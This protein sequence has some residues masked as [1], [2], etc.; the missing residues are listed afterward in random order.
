MEL[1][2]LAYKLLINYLGFTPKYYCKKDF[3]IKNKNNFKSYYDKANKFLRK[4]KLK[5]L[6]EI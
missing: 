5:A 3:F 2:N 1:N 6:H 4:E